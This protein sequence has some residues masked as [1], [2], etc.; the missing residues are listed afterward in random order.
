MDRRQE[1]FGNGTKSLGPAEHM[2]VKEWAASP[3]Q[4]Y[5]D[6]GAGD[7]VVIVLV[8]QK[9]LADSQVG[10]HSMDRDMALGLFTAMGMCLRDLGVELPDFDKVTIGGEGTVYTEGEDT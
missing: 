7:G 6:E 2:E 4:Y 5:N 10:V 3:A 1:L 9:H 8:S